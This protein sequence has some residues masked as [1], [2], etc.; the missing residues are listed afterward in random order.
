MEKQEQLSIEDKK[1]SVCREIKP[2]SEFYR[3]KI[4]QCKTCRSAV[5]GKWRAKHK[6]KLLL[7]MKEN[8]KEWYE[9]N[10]E[11]VKQNQAIYAK[12]N[13][14]SVNAQGSKTQGDAIKTN[15]CVV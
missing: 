10:K 5:I 14:S 1:C 11:K 7:Q 9:K 15:T 3:Q 8:S 6:E 2:L 12:N 13:K 4:N